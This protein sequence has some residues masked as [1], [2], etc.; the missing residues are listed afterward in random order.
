MFDEA[1]VENM[2]NNR[3]PPHWQQV[4]ILNGIDFRAAHQLGWKRIARASFS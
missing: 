1:S 2:K 4:Q 3:H